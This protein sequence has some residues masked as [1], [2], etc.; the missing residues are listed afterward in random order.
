VNV[1]LGS[2]APCA[3]ARE[4]PTGGQD[5][6]LG[7]QRRKVVGGKAEDRG[8][9]IVHAGTDIEREALPEDRGLQT[10]AHTGAADELRVLIP[11]GDRSRDTRFHLEWAARGADISYHAAE[12]VAGIDHE[13][14][15]A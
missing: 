6:E 4:N 7:G 12:V 1:Y 15:A 10:C 8:R 14:A 13:V 2:W 11:E 9:E 3:F 5:L